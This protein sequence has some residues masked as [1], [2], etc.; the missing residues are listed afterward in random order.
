MINEIAKR[1]ATK[2]NL[3]CVCWRSGICKRV[4]KLMKVT[5]SNWTLEEFNWDKIRMFYDRAADWLKDKCPY[6]DIEWALK[7]YV[8]EGIKTIDINRMIIKSA[9]DLITTEN[10]SWQIIAWR[11]MIKNLYKE[12][13]RATWISVEEVY[14]PAY[15]P[16]LIHL[17]VEKWLYNSKITE[18]Y[19]DEDI[20]ELAEYINPATDYE[21]NH[22]TVNMYI[23]RYLINREEL[24]VRELPQHMYLVNAM[25]LGMPEKDEDRLEFVKKLYDAT[26]KGEISLPTPTLLNA[27]TPNSQLSSCFIMT[28]A[29]DLRSIYHNIEGM[30]QISKNGWG[31]WVYAGNIRSKGSYIKW[32]KGLS[33][34]VM[35]WIKVINDTAIAVNQMWK[36]AGAISIT[37]DIF[38]RDIYDW[39]EMQTETGDVRNKAFDVF[40]AVSIPDLFME[41][42][43]ARDKWTL[44]DPYEV[45]KVTWKRLQDHFWDE[46]VSF[47]E[48]LEQDDRLTMKE[49][50]DALELFKTFLKTVTETWMPYTFFRDT[51]NRLNPNKHAWN[52]Y[53]SNLCTEIAQNQSENTFILEEDDDWVITTKFQSGD[54]VICNLASI[55][56]AKV[57]TKEKL[58]EIVS[59]AMRTLDNVIDLNAYPIK[60]TEISAKKYRAV[61][62]GM[63]WLAQYFAENKLIYWS[64]DS[65][66]KSDEL[67]KNIAY[68]TL[69][70]SNQL[71]KER[72][73]Y[74]MFEWSEYSKGIAF[75]RNIKDD[76]S[77]ELAYD[78]INSWV[79]FGYHSSP[80]PNTSTASVVGTTAGIVPIYKKYFVETNS[81]APTVTVAP[82][83]NPDNF[84]MYQEYVSIELW[85]V[86]DVVSTLQK[87][88]D[89]SISFEWLINPAKTSPKDLFMYFIKAHEQWIKTVYYVRSQSLEVETCESCAG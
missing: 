63:M 74:P 62:L 2:P 53:C 31:I 84:W 19:S 13:S 60:E 20:L 18:I 69:K 14:A 28:P 36:R 23:R 58:S 79:R 61:G 37:L 64:E 65:I 66:K 77:A 50:T 32:V 44:F 10:I 57:N 43:K 71:A 26:S 15:L 54:T 73:P 3:V 78:I 55:N 1:C 83:L 52:I 25:F 4:R 59:I 82:N 48:E 9:I 34:G 49:T 17:Y 39:L 41:R 72:W 80:A 12:W 30:A 29:D 70:A 33:G 11:F 56:V 81:I 22:W 40:P 67:F 88:I 87:W 75:W 38:H 85:W 21:Y 27:R 5:K 89:Q 68:Y 24:W 76:F 47:Y 45:E 35:P 6:E 42:M 46:F 7:N 86:I 51:V 8:V 16:N